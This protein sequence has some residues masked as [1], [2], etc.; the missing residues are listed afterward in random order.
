MFDFFLHL[1]FSISLLFQTCVKDL[2]FLVTEPKKWIKSPSCSFV[3][4]EYT[5]T[6]LVSGQF[7]TLSRKKF[8]P[9]GTSLQPRQD[10]LL[11]S[12]HNGRR[13][14]ICPHQLPPKNLFLVIRSPIFSPKFPPFLVNPL[15]LC[16]LEIV[17][18]RTDLVWYRCVFWI[19]KWI[20]RVSK[21][22]PSLELLSLLKSVPNSGALSSGSQYAKM[23]KA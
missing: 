21:R 9:C 14:A 12:I 3:V 22:N 10:I 5:L 16:P 7:E 15:H 6:L 8:A 19:H 20:V 2:R 23:R 1:Q 4:K 18:R 11:N 17:P 13:L